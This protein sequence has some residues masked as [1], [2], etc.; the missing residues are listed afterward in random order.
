MIR[1]VTKRFQEMHALKEKFVA[2]TSLGE[3]HM[4]ALG[5]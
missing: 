3:P 4:P 2:V 5:R 1:D